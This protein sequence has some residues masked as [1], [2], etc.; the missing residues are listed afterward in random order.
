M[1][2][3][4]VVQK[5]RKGE[6]HFNLISTNGQIVATSQRYATKQAC[7]RGVASVKKLAADA[8]V[9]DVSAQEPTAGRAKAK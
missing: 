8:A 6:F 4:F 5:S 7:M 3:K 2:G 1:P 9:H